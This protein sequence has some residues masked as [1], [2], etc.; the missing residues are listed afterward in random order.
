[1]K[2][3]NN[4]NE[5]KKSKTFFDNI[6][7]KIIAI[8]QNDNSMKNQILA[9]R[10]ALSPSACLRRVRCLEVQGVFQKHVAII[11]LE[12]LGYQIVSLVSII[13]ENRHP[14]TRQDFESKILRLSEVKECYFMS[15]TVDYIL[16][17][18]VKNMMEYDALMRGY[19][20]TDSRIKTFKSYIS[21]KRVQYDTS[22]TLY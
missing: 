5:I 14:N 15:D 16:I 2:N 4:K 7:K 17:I 6:D 3:K 11:D 9:S 22:I 20:A 21:L 18:N 1:M 13:L 12:Q 10:I 19:F 8:L